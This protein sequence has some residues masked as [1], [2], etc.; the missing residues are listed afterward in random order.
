MK[1]SPTPRKW[2]RVTISQLEQRGLMIDRREET[3]PGT[4]GPVHCCRYWLA[5]DSRERA[6]ELLGGGP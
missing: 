2:Q 3:V 6:R 1:S 4:F 5:D